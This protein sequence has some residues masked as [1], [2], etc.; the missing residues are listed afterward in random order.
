MKLGLSKQV[1]EGTLS[2]VSL[3][4]IWLTHSIFRFQATF[5][6]YVVCLGKNLPGDSTVMMLQESSLCSPSVLE[7]RAK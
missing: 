7:P 3:W 1:W 4:T 5:K 2:S 6:C